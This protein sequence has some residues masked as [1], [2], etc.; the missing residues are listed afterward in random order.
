MN[1]REMKKRNDNFNKVHLRNI[2]NKFESETGV[3]LKLVKKRYPSRVRFAVVVSVI[4]CLFVGTPALAANIPEV[5][6]LMYLVSPD[7]AQFFLPIQLSDEDEGIQ[8]EVVS[9][10][11]HDDVIKVYVTVQD[12]T[13]DRIDDTTDLYDSYSINRPFDS[14]AYCQFIGFDETSRKATFLISISEWGKQ[15][16]SGEKITF[17]IKEIISHKKTYKELEIPIEH[18]EIIS[19]QETQDVYSSGESGDYGVNGGLKK[20]LKPSMEIAFIPEESIK[21]SAIGFIDNQLHVQMVIKDRLALD[22]HGLFYLEDQKGN[23][24]DSSSNLYFTDDFEQN[25]DRLDYCEYIFDVSEKSISDY[26]LLGDFVITGMKI[27]GD[28]QVTFPLE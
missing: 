27:K 20:V 23:K 12:L 7:I 28:W 6:R 8:M 22:H 16:V 13:Q 18:N 14:S 17:S 24:L 11:T 5:Y 21:L 10:Y 9:V 15:K 2:K 26:K 1:N 3:Q 19:N 25:I 4:L